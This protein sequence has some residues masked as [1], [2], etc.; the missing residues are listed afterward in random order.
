MTVKEFKTPDGSIQK[1]G[2]KLWFTNLDLDKNHEE[3][4]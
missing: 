3:Y 4:L 2:N 1:F